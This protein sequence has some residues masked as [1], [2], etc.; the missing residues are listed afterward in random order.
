M[1]CQ[2][3]QKYWINFSSHGIWNV[4]L[5]NRWRRLAPLL[6]AGYSNSISC[7]YSHHST[8][9]AHDATFV[10]YR[11]LNSK[12]KNRAL[13]FLNLRLFSAL[14]VF[15]SFKTIKVWVFWEGHKIW[16]NLRRT[17]D[18]S[19]LICVC[20]SVD[21]DFSKQ[22]WPSRIIQTLQPFALYIAEKTYISL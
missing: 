19:V 14:Y 6:R 3:L 7:S 1:I 20:N 17:F 18:K 10:K 9:D 21:E 22:M 5:S 11:S 13:I 15:V 8:T 4:K 16:K 2:N 12:F